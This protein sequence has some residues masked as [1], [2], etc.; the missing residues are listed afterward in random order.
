MSTPLPRFSSSALSN[1]PTRKAPRLGGAADFEAADVEATVQRFSELNP[2]ELSKMPRKML[3][4]IG[5]MV[6]D[7][8]RKQSVRNNLARE[9]EVLLPVDLLLHTFS[10]LSAAQLHASRV[11]KYFERAVRTGVFLRIGGI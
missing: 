8:L 9:V 2:E 1:Q 5:S 7:A 11:C 10:F 4:L 3:M 6:F